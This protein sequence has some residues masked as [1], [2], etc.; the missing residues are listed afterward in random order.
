MT[1]VDEKILQ[2]IPKETPI[3]L[4]INKVDCLKDKTKT[5]RINPSI[6]GE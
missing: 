2:M 6:Q 1:E 4:V 3:I 5:F